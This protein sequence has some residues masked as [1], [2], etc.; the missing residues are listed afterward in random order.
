MIAVAA[1]AALAAVAPSPCADPALALRCPDLVMAPPSHMRLARSPSGR[2]VLRM[3]N[4]IVN[5]GVGPAELFGQ[6]VSAVEMRA[7][8]VIADA[9]GRRHRFETGAELYYKSVPSR[10]GSYWKFKD[11]ARFELWAVDRSAH[12]TQLVRIGPKLDYCL[13]DLRRARTGPTVRRHR[14]YPGCNQSASKRE[15]TLGTS[16]GWA[17]AYPSRYPDN[18]IDVTGLSG[19]FAVVHRVDPLHHIFE[20][21]DANNVSSKIVRL[22]FKPGPQHCPRLPPPAASA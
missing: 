14:L 16:V 5:V 22:P 17:D 9:S 19:C 18:W 20:S 6:R 4:R 8:Q 11:A 21:N 10:G 3:E 12:R 2:S 7:R 13:R 15:V 1:F